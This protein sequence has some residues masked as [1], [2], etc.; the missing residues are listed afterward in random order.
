LP[1]CPLVLV[2]TDVVQRF[3]ERLAVAGVS[4]QLLRGEVF[5]LLGPNG[6]GKTTTIRMAMGLLRPTSGTVEYEGIGSPHDP[7]VRRHLGVAPQ[8][9]ALYERLS[10]QE[11]LLYFGSLY[12]LRGAKL[13]TRAHEVL[14]RVGL[15]DRRHEQ[16]GAFSGGMQRRLNLASALLHEPKVLL[17]DEPTA[18]VDPQSRNSILELVG[19]L[20]DGGTTV[21]Y[22][23]HYMEEAQRLCDRV[24]IIDQGQLC[25][26][27]TVDELIHRH[28]GNS[29]LILERADGHERREVEHLTPALVA[30]AAEPGLTGLRVEKPSL[31]AVFLNLTGRRLRD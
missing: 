11:H 17:L 2:M 12:G 26:V 31:E 7:Q 21:L 15:V 30:A 9:L 24:G 23:T 25:D 14:E 16:V 13:Q 28:G 18:G 5:G 10:A 29:A 8:R 4:L 1:Y 6:A 22:T 27:G 20:R 3:G 19:S